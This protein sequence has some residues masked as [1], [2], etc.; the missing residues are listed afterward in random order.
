MNKIRSMLSGLGITTR[1]MVGFLGISLIPCIVLTAITNRLATR[2]L[3]AGLRDRLQ[4]ISASK[5]LELNSFI[6]ERQGNLAVLGQISTTQAAVID[7]TR[8]LDAG[9]APAAAAVG[10]RVR[11]AMRL[12]CETY[13]YENVLLFD[14]GGRLLHGLEGG[15]D[16]GPGLLSG[17]LKDSELAEVFRRAR[18]LLQG[19]V[20]DFQSYPGLPNPALFMAQPVL[21]DGVLIGLV[22]LQ[23][24]NKEIYRSFQDYSGLGETGE[25][26]VGMLKGDEIMFV[27]PLRHDPDAAF[28]RRIPMGSDLSQA[29]QLAVR[30]VHGYGPVNDYRGEQAVAAWSY[31]PA[32]RWGLNVKQDRAEAFAM[33]DQQRWAVGSLLAATTALVVLAAWGMARTITRPIRQAALLADRVAAG[34][35]TATCQERAPGEIGLLLTAIRKMNHDLRSLIGRIQKSSISLLSTATEIA[36]TSRQQ[37]QAVYE[38]GASTNEAAAAVN[39][40]SA[41][42]QE[43]LKTMTEV[44]AVVRDAAQQ[45]ATGRDGL[46][47]M[48]RTMRQLAEST[49]SIGSKLSVISERAA[50]INMVVTTITKVADQT[51]LLSINAA[52]EAEKA[53]EYGLGFLVVAREIRRLADQTAV[54]TLDIERMV[55]EMQ[56]S[57]SA[58]VME[59]DKFSEQVRAVVAE[60]Q[61]IGGQ[62]GSII[63]G[64]Q[65]LDERFEQVT[66][67]MRVQSQGADQIREAMLRLS[68]VAGQTTSSLREFNSATDHLREAVG[69]LKEEVSRFTVGNVDVCEL[70]A[71]RPS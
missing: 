22:A 51:N 27:A 39:E 18:T 58:G 10:A 19:E 49:G 28:K 7:L 59:M 4:A 30:G 17:P 63:A 70:P 1:L 69:G 13:G 24:G 9:D 52:I 23:V 65:G 12:F 48:D 55:K 64:V 53:G 68:E 16:V 71:P 3:E 42:S 31:I 6:R 26:L 40:I 29:V 2:S 20:S 56:Y 47:G 60:V 66:E 5:A 37:E 44:N 15:L 14:V 36:A 38:Y 11:P 57:V 34:D 33:I 8:A 25:A 32:F 62:L 45:A 46:T 21:K 61:Q 43:L 50:N 35:L 41:T 67:G 54:A